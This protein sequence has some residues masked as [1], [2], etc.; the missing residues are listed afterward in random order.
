MTRHFSLLALVL[1]FAL[2][3]AAPVFAGNENPGQ[4]Q[5]P[6]SDQ[7]QADPGQ[8]DQGQTDQ[9]SPEQGKDKCS[10][11]DLLK[12]IF[13]HPK[14]EAALKEAMQKLLTM[15]A[16]DLQLCLDTIA[17]KDSCYLKNVVPAVGNLNHALSALDKIHPPKHLKPVFKELH[18]RISHAKFYLVV[19]DREEAENRVRAALEYIGTLKS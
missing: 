4:N 16:Q 10:L 7:G 14:D 13:C 6:A 9:G 11:L 2:T 12:K 15:T 5:P 18:K 19:N 8:N 3:V 17:G 1:C